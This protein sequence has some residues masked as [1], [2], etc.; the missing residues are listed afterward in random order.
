MDVTI[1]LLRTATRE[2]AGDPA[3][4]RLADLAAARAWS[5]APL[6]AG[7]LQPL[8]AFREQ[9]RDALRADAS[10]S[11]APAPPT[12]STV[13]LSF[14]ASGELSYAAAGAGWRAVAWLVT[15]ELL[16]A[17]AAGTLRRLKTCAYEP[18]GWPFVDESRNVSRVWHDTAKCGNV[19]NLRARRARQAR[20]RQ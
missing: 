6:K 2:H 13:D 5:P 16:L 8:R 9:V 7:D 17:R 3:W 11:D 20:P 10:T 12:V 19:V 4:D 1:G 15:M 18:C 14:A